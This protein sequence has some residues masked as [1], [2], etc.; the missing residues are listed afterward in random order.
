MR[1]GLFSSVISAAIFALWS[2]VIFPL[3]SGFVDIIYLKNGNKIDVEKCWVEGKQVKFLTEAGLMAIPLDTVQ[4]I[5]K[6]EPK[7][8]AAERP[9]ISSY[10][11]MDKAPHDKE[12]EIETH[13]LPEGSG[14]TAP[15]TREEIIKLEEAYRK[16]SKDKALKLRLIVARKLLVNHLIGQGKFVEAVEELK[17]ILLLQ[18]SDANVR[19]ALGALYLRLGNISMAETHLREALLIDYS[20]ADAHYLMGEVYYRQ[21][22][23]PQAIEQWRHSLQLRPREDLRIRLEQLIREN[24]ARA[25]YSKADSARFELKYFG[26]PNSKLGDEILSALESMYDDLSRKLD[27]LPRE[28]IVVILYSNEDFYDTTGAPRMVE[29]I[30]DGKVRIPIGGLLS[31]PYQA[32][33]VLIHELTHAF[34][35]EK[36]RGNCPLWLHEGIAQYMEGLSAK[37]YSSRLAL[38]LKKEGFEALPLY[39][40]SL[41]MVE[42][43]IETYGFFDLL[44]ILK[45]LGEGKSLDYTLKQYLRNSF[46]EFRQEWAEK[47]LSSIS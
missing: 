36:T 2:M 8:S 41:S 4:R 38:L 45:A 3:S 32:R 40:A 47:M 16:N 7:S 17:D 11:P 10:A 34:L 21:E 1:A 23:L 46:E 37:A 12:T 35:Y 14:N 39:P 20:D 18:S 13:L 27:Y 31:L 5:E 29:G 19:K 28:I 9:F 15:P 6:S 25:G 22:K 30:Y 42:Y 43:L 44:R 26:P 24:N 33:N